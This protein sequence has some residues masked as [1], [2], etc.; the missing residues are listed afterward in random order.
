MTSTPNIRES[1]M[2]APVR[3]RYAEFIVLHCGGFDK[4]ARFFMDWLK[5]HHNDDWEI[6]RACD[7]DGERLVERI[8][9]ELTN[10]DLDVAFEADKE[11]WARALPRL[12]KFSEVAASGRFNPDDVEV[13]Q[14]SDGMGRSV[15]TR[16]PF[17]R[18]EVV[19]SYGG[20]VVPAA[21]GAKSDYMLQI[22]GISSSTATRHPPGPRQARWPASAKGGRQWRGN[23]ARR[24]DVPPRFAGLLG[25]I[26][27]G[28]QARR[29]S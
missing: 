15:R 19:C 10:G 1:D 14:R 23:V 16:R 12:A 2:F 18:G 27:N 20:Q 4:E 6:F 3:T 7:D 8:V 13:F 26:G 17:K 25:R 21:V 29:R 9:E 5:R 11:R 24:R 28:D 22:T